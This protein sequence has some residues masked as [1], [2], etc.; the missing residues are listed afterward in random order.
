V[1]Y[2]PDGMSPEEYKRLKENERKNAANKKFAA[3]GPQTFQ[4]RSMASFQKDLEQ[5]KAG[6]LLPVFNAKE[7]LQKGVIKKEDIPYMQR[8][9]AWDNSDVK[10]AKRKEW[11]EMD[12]KY[13]AN[14]NQNLK[15]DWSGQGKQKGGPKSQQVAKNAASKKE[16][17]K[18]S[19]GFFGLF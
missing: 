1:A 13:N 14:A 3:F 11:N 9:G 12:Q 6:H 15:L 10:T 2:V 16:A 7:K 4:S 17:P 8:G 19:G 18:K 5:G